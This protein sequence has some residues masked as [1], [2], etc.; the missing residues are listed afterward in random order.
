MVVW[1]RFSK[2]PIEF[3]DRSMLKEIGS[4]I[5]PVLR[6]DSYTVSGTRGSY[7]RL[8]VQVDL[9]KP[10][11][12][13]VRI[14]KCR[15]VVLYEGISALCFSCGHLGHTQGNCC[16]NIKPCEKGG[17]VGEASKE[18][19][20]GQPGDTTT[21]QDVGQDFQPSP[22]Y[23]PWM[24]VTRK[25]SLVRNGRGSNSVKE[26]SGSEGYK[27]KTKSSFET[28]E[29][30]LPGLAR[31]D[32]IQQVQDECMDTVEVDLLAN[33]INRED[34]RTDLQASFEEGSFRKPTQSSKFR[35]AK[36]LGIKNSKTLK[37]RSKWP[38][39]NKIIT[40]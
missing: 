22:N 28:L 39:G 26:N 19:N 18:Q 30:T 15:Q 16:N 36:S 21:I 1:V 6:I 35:L 24:L 5:G 29:T 32:V 8:C 25:R 31:E 20:V 9:E 37:R 4:V 34:L 2:L 27:G 33:K 40:I 10:L 11:I 38:N 14:G 3:Y 13:V 23:G 7:A 12:N 17:E